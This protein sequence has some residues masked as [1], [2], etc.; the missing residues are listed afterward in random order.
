[1]SNTT[2]AKKIKYII[3]DLEY[4]KDG[5]GNWVLC[6]LAYRC[7][8]R[9]FAY[10]F[11]HSVY[12]VESLQCPKFVDEAIKRE[13]SNET[14]YKVQLRRPEEYLKLFYCSMQLERDGNIEL[15]GHNLF[16]VDIPSLEDLM[17]EYGYPFYWNDKGFTKEAYTEGLFSH[18]SHDTRQIA[19][20]YRAVLNSNNIKSKVTLKDTA[21]F[22]EVPVVEDKLHDASY[23]CWLTE[24]IFIKDKEEKS[25]S[26]Y[27]KNICEREANPLHYST[28]EPYNKPAR[29]HDYCEYGD[30]G[31]TKEAFVP[32]NSDNYEDIFNSPTKRWD[33]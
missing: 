5:Q 27:V 1:M 21:K 20:G 33:N 15:V 16:S 24:Q 8:N 9:H 25:L 10:I 4:R 6:Q 7:L 19:E 18:S 22:F 14:S 26:T 17:H 31:F 28:P 12:F 32:P 29:N 3:L 23:D 13:F 11:E 30:K 2:F